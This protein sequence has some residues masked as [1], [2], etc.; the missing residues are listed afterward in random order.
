MSNSRVSIL[1]I[2]AN[3]RKASLEIDEYI[4]YEKDVVP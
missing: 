4:K 1:L 3:P 2:E